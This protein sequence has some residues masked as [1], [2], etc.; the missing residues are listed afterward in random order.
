M[1]LDILRSDIEI[2]L[3]YF[4]FS[5]LSTIPPPCGHLPE[6]HVQYSSARKSSSKEN[7]TL[8]GSGQGVCTSGVTLDP[9]LSP[10]FVGVQ[11]S[12]EGDRG[13]PTCWARFV[14]KTR[15]F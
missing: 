15:S 5:S 8:D 13:E 1:S 6:M 10:D 4:F 3:S 12:R 7:V 11:G 9:V 2:H 14:L